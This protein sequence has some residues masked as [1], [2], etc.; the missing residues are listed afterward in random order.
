MSMSRNLHRSRLL[1]SE[2]APH[3]LTTPL[4][5]PRESAARWGVKGE[6]TPIV[7]L[8]ATCTRTRLR[9]LSA[10]IASSI[11]PSPCPSHVRRV[12]RLRG[13]NIS[14]AHWC[15]GNMSMSRNLHRSRLLP[16]PLCL[17]GC[18]SFESKGFALSCDASGRTERM[19]STHGNQYR[20]FLHSQHAASPPTRPLSPRVSTK[21]IR[22][23]C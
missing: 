23:R 1:P 3:A 9:P 11:A 12:M 4:S 22:E 6:P 8:F 19:F 21:R 17:A 14:P 7:P 15:A 20:Q 18:P 2:C 13:I 5:H 10:S 16:S